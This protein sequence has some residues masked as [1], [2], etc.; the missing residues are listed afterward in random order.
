MLKKICQ[1]LNYRYLQFK[2]FPDFGYLYLMYLIMKGYV[3]FFFELVFPVKKSAIPIDVII[4]V[5]PK[6]VSKL[7]NCLIGIQKNVLHPISKIF[8]IGIMSNEL[9][10]IEK[11]FKCTH[12]NEKEL[13]DKNQLK[14]KYIYN[15]IDRS[16]WL[17]QQFLNYQGV[18]DLG[19]EN[20]KLA[21]DADTVFSKKQKFI[22]NGKMVF[23]AT[24]SYHYPYFFVAS[25]LL[26]LNKMTKVSFTSHHILYNK[27]IFTEMINYIEK[28]YNKKWYKAILNVLNFSILSNHS[29]FET[30]AQ[31]V[32]NNYKKFVIVEYWF[33][34]DIYEKDLKS[35]SNIFDTF[36]YKSLSFHHWLNLNKH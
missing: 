7:E 3:I 9:D 27:K 4:T 31:F 20:F 8:V 22:K 10:S 18:L 30:Y 36:F 14:I 24:N 16:G 17:F 11:K 35:F 29:D 6:D 13:L 32:M 1:F 5:A 19:N 28:K 34:K 33:N 21:V 12:V 23:N 26:D 25:Q 2:S 15:N